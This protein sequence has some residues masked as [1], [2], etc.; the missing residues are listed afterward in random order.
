[1][2]QMVGQD[3]VVQLQQILSRYKHDRETLEKE[4]NLALKSYQEA[5]GQEK[6]KEIQKDL[7]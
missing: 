5:L 7:Q 2:N 6:I 3:K 1:M 4:L